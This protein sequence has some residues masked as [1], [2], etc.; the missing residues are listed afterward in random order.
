MMVDLHSHILPGVDD[1]SQSPEES[2]EMLRMEAEQGIRLVVATPHFRGGYDNPEEFLER[3]CRAEQILRRE[4][5]K[6]KGLPEIAM[7]AE[8]SFFRG[9]SDWNLLPKLAIENTACVL[10]E[11]PFTPWPDAFYRELEQIW[12]NHR[13]TPVIA[14]IDRYIGGFRSLGNPRRLAEMP[15]LIQANADFFLRRGRAGSAMKML[16]ADQ[17]HLLGSDCHN[18]SS[19]KPNL[20]FAVERIREKLGE[21]GPE[22][23]AEYERQIFG[24]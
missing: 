13:I 18:L 1:G 10:I 24:I 11:M 15:V 9:M 21:D 4:M 5:A 16:K 3:R 23:I 14:H 12:Q 20:G 8:V 22:R 6:Q 2:I 17:I 7:G 19:R